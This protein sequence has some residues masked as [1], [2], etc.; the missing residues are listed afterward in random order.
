M[1]SSLLSM[2]ALLR[3]L[4]STGLRIGEAL[5]LK[6]QDVN[7]EENYLRV[8]DS[9]N[10]QE[11]IIPISDS[12]V[13][14]CQDYL[15]YRHLLP[16]QRP[17]THFFVKLDGRRC[18]RISV[19]TWF[20]RCLHQA[21]IPY[22]GRN[23]GPRIHDLRH[24]FAVTSLASMAEAGIDLYVSLPVLSR[25]LGHQSLEATN[26]YVRLTASMYPD[27]IRDID[28]VCLDVFPKLHHYEAD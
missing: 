28:T 20:K 9:K 15:R 25:Y 21:G 12:L 27:L 26:H 24:T 10:D 18:G 14:V 19:S 13:S 3:L 6:D 23:Y 7:L 2:P 17:P 11:R 1:G 16:L 22:I 4:Y 5:D 8:K